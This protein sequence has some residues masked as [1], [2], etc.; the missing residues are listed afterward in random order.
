MIPIGGLIANLLVNGFETLGKS[1]MQ[2]GAEKLTKVIKDKTGVD[3]SDKKKI[4]FSQEEYEKLR[5]FEKDELALYLADVQ[6][7]RD[8]NISL[9]N[10]TGSWLLKNTGSLI[11]IITI[12][13]GFGLF[14]LLI[15][16]ELSIENSN[17]ALIVGFIGGYISQ[18]H[19]FY[20]GTSKNEAD[21]QRVDN[22]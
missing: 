9:A 11:A 2:D 20:F 12:I 17:V 4:D 5:V 10:S 3:L 21:K 13:F 18:I 22:G 15:D 1:L 6:N 7:A 14:Y 19:G 16:G 8:M